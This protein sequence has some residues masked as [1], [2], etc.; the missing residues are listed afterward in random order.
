MKKIKL[1]IIFLMIFSYSK[2]QNLSYGPILGFN[3]YDISIGG[4]INDGAGYSGLNFGGFLEHQFNSSFGVRGNIIY[5]NIKEGKHYV[6]TGNQITSYLFDKAEI[7][8]LQIQTLLKYDVNKDYNKGFYII[9]GFRMSNILNVKLDGQK[10]EDFY[11][12][13]SFGAMLGF[14]VNFAKHFGLELIPEINLTNPINSKINKSRNI[15]GYLNLT[16]N[17]ESIIKK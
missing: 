12:R 15:G 1:S 6:V 9:G 16:L 4:P 10:N 5:N 3:A 17:L 7:Q 13:E 11:K 2:G 14:G 8:S